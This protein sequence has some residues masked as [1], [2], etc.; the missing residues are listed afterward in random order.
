MFVPTPTEVI[1]TENRNYLSY[2]DYEVLVRRAQA[3]RAEYFLALVTRAVRAL[4]AK[5]GKP[6]AG[7]DKPYGKGPLAG[8]NA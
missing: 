4:R 7:N 8:A 3:E 6:A 5:F 1:M 2:R